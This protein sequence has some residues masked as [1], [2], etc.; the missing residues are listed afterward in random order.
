MTH[1]PVTHGWMRQAIEQDM[2]TQRTQTHQEDLVWRYDQC[3]NADRQP[4]RTQCY[5]KEKKAVKRFKSS[6]YWW[7]RRRWY[8][9]ARWKQQWN[10]TS[11]TATRWWGRPSPRWWFAAGSK[12]GAVSGFRD[13]TTSLSSPPVKIKWI[14]WQKYIFWG[15]DGVLLFL[16]LQWKITRVIK[17]TS[18]KMNPSYLSHFLG[19]GWENF[20]PLRKKICTGSRNQLYSCAHFCLLSNKKEH[21]FKRIICPV[22]RCFCRDA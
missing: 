14:N 3:D 1:W 20:N 15:D 10:A 7:R 17:G 8:Y 2:S 5:S 11:T 4:S 22:S 9:R 13:W 12:P 16:L 21:L 19:N 18:R 6:L